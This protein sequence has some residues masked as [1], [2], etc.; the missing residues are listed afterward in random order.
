MR[1]RYEAWLDKKSLSAIDP[2]IYIRD[3]AYEAP[4]FMTMANDVPGRNGQRV[5]NRHAQTSS[6]VIS[7]EIHEQD[8][9]R[10]HEIMMRVQAWAAKGG[11]LTTN[12]RRGQQLRVMCEELPAI[13]SALKWTQALKMTFTAYEQPFWEDEHPRT[14][15]LEGT[16][17]GKSLYAPGNS[18]LTR[19]EVRVE[20]KSSGVLNA[21]LLRAGA[22][23][24]DLDGLGLA[25]GEVLDIDYD[26]NG[27]LRI[28]AGDV[29]KMHCRSGNSDDDLM[30]ETGTY[31]TMMINASGNVKVTFKARGLYL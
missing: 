12:D 8:V 28:H 19:V 10:R 2:A 21:V 13:S 14:A 31:S 22:T 16:S 29:S 18:A 23:K 27:L 11:K 4:R 3:I 24:F 20:N 9:A 7:F 30:I 1:T 5:T 17:V 15:V 26:E 25:S 6:V